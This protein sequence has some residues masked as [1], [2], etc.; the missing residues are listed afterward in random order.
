M[1]KILNIAAIVIGVIMILVA[2]FSTLKGGL[3]MALGFVV[4]GGAMYFFLRRRRD[5]RLA[6][7]DQGDKGP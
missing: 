6:M 5:E 4:T 3:L 2:D 7:Q 1:N